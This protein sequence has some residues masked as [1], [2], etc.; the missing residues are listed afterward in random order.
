MIDTLLQAATRCKHAPLESGKGELHTSESF[1]DITNARLLYTEEGHAATPVVSNYPE[2]GFSFLV[3][4]L[5]IE[6]VIVHIQGRVLHGGLTRQGP[7]VSYVETT[8][9]SA[10]V[11]TAELLDW[12]PELG[13]LDVCPVHGADCA[14]WV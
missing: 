13:C 7:V 8:A 10:M 5:G 2:R 9:G 11:T 3:F 4:D 1:D 6:S 14:A 12:N